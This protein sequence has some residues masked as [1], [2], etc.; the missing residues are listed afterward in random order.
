MVVVARRR[1]GW[2]AL[3][4]E[5]LASLGESVGE[6]CGSVLRSLGLPSRVCPERTVYESKNGSTREP[7]TENI[8]NGIGAKTKTRTGRDGM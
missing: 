6:W 7:Q 5:R 4:C 8:L 3:A 2:I 1:C